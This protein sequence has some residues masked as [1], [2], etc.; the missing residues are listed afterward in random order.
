MKERTVSINAIMFDRSNPRITVATE[1]SGAVEGLLKKCGR[2]IVALATDILKFGINP[3]DRIMCVAYKDANGRIRYIAKEGNRR[4]LAI[5][6]LLNPSICVELQWVNK[7]KRLVKGSDRDL[8]ALRQVKIVVFDDDER[9]ELD[10][11]IRIKHEGEGDGTGTVKWGSVEKRRYY[12]GDSNDFAMA[13]LH[14]VGNYSQ[15]PGIENRPKFPITTFERIVTSTDGKEILGVKFQDGH[16]VASRKVEQLS[17]N[18]MQVIEDL[19]TPSAQNPRRMRVNVSDVKSKTDIRNYLQ[20]F[21]TEENAAAQCLPIELSVSVASGNTES[22]SG[23][24]SSGALPQTVL[25]PGTQ[26]YLR[27]LIKTVYPTRQGG[28]VSV[29][30]QEMQ[31]LSIREVPLSFGL[32]LRTLID[33]SSKLFC[34]NNGLSVLAG[35]S[36]RDRVTRCKGKLFQLTT[37]WEISPF[38]GKIEDA[39]RV[40]SG[41]TLLSFTEMNSLVHGMEAL[42]STETFLK[43]VPRIIPIIRAL[44]GDRPQ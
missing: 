35:E 33:I 5:K 39:M 31:R 40:L 21:N 7:F 9:N 29:L 4:L 20:K 27:A 38:R 37:G 16:L 44:N 25:T 3:S 6:A 24:R 18:L 34:E 42:P 12:S 14:W 30:T 10:H 15:N 13:L 8:A 17:H 11:W 43:Y 28:K 41:D 19:T 23:R 22:P 1:Q 36:L 26:E 2:K 32:A